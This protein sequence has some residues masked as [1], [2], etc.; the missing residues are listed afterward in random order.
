MADALSARLLEIKLDRLLERC[1]GLA[2]REDKTD[3]LVVSIGIA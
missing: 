2:A 3:F 1:T